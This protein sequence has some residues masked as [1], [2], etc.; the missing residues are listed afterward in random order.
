M[1]LTDGFELRAPIVP[2]QIIDDRSK[3]QLFF[4][5]HETQHPLPFSRFDKA[6]LDSLRMRFLQ[7][8]SLLQRKR[9]QRNFR[10]YGTESGVA[11][12]FPY[13]ERNFRCNGMKLLIFRFRYNES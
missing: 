5:K 13:K 4:I 10:Y 9:L 6:E 3:S 12:K 7:S 2:Y 8:N 11:V 1:I